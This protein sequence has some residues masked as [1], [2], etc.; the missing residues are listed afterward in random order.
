MHGRIFGQDTDQPTIIESAIASLSARAAFR[1]RRHH[2]LTRRAVLI[3]ETN[4]QLPGYQRQYQEIV[5]VTPT[6]D[7]AI[8]TSRLVQV[9]S[10]VF[11]AGLRYHRANILFHDLVSEQSLQADLF[12]LVD[13][14]GS[15]ASHHR[16]QAL[17]AINTRYG[18]GTLRYAAEALSNQWEPKHNLRSPRYTTQWHELP[19]VRLGPA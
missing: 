13:L 19:L 5:L 11:Q 6:A 16:M 9:L 10:E 8:L 7:T 14:P 12:G 17:D 4:R 18:S 2:L 3:L 1:L 15:E